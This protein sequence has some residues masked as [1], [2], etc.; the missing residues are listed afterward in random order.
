VRCFS[1][2][3]VIVDEAARVPDDLYRAVR[4]M[5]A[6]SQGRLIALSTPFGQR[7]WFYDELHGSGPKSTSAAKFW[8]GCSMGHGSWHC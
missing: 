3:L 8:A 2:G 7:G 6:V 4:P 1:P 5:L